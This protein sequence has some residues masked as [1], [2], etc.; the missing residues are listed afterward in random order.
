MEKIYLEDNQEDYQEDNQED[1][2]FQDIVFMSPMIGHDITQQNFEIGKKD[3]CWGVNFP[4]PGMMCILD[5]NELKGDV[6][7]DCQ[8]K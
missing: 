1:I 3:V 8:K 7:I 5:I 4:L 6:C 2:I